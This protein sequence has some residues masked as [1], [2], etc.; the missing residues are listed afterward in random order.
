[1]DVAQSLSGYNRARLM[2]I[3]VVFCH[4]FIFALNCYGDSEGTSL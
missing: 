3:P 4:I 2:L 1:M